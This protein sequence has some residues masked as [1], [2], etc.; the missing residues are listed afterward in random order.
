[1]KYLVNRSVRKVYW[2]YSLSRG[3]FG[4][5]LQVQFPVRIEGKGG[6][7]FGKNGHLNKMVNIGISKFSFLKVGDNS[8][9]E[10]QCSVLITRQAKLTI[11]N[12]FKLGENARLY[13]HNNWLIGNNVKI[14]THCSIF[15]REP[16]QFGILSIGNGSRIGDHTI[17]DVVDNVSI[18]NE[19]AIGPNC[20]LY[21]HDHLY[22]D[23]NKPAWKGG[24]T[25]APIVIED[26]AWIGSNVTILP[27]VV[28]ASKAVVA[29]G[30]VVN[31]D[32]EAHS[33]YAGVPAKLIKKINYD[34]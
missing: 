10:T 23:F 8:L 24:L 25:K 14:E 13:V 5:G 3:K 22:T 16:E 9:F 32:V 30:S 12:G 27:G 31:K 2:L 28:I 20:T 6:V 15:A 29:A 33:I 11:G 17:I 1:M 18:G 4:K 7:E 21:T 19:V 34:D 26:G